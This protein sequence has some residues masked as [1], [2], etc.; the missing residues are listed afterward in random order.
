MKRTHIFLPDQIVRRIDTIIGG[1]S[2]RSSFIVQAT[3]KELTRQEQIAALK[4]AAGS[5]SDDK[6]PELKQGAAKWVKTLRRDYENRFKTN[7]AGRPSSS[8]ATRKPQTP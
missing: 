8:R 7:I 4:S 2:S 3:E 1:K 5:W 6:H